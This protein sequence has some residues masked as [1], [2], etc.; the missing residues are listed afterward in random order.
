MEGAFSAAC[1]G[2]SELE[3][4][5]RTS[6]NSANDKQSVNAANPKPLEV[7]V[8][9]ENLTQDEHSVRFAGVYSQAGIQLRAREQQ[10][11]PCAVRKTATARPSVSGLEMG[12]RKCEPTSS[13]GS[14][15]KHAGE[16]LLRP[17]QWGVVA[18]IV[19]GLQ[20]CSF[21]HEGVYGLRSWA[22]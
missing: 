4:V 1:C 15:A 21:Q 20:G 16:V 8:L 10:K 11:P 14:D 22:A 5:A 18:K 19:E 17:R 2:V 9:M 13:T 6:A 3:L 12:W 7:K